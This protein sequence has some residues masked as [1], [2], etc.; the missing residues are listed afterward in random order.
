MSFHC[1]LKNAYLATNYIF[2]VAFYGLSLSLNQIIYFFLFFYLE[3]FK[4][5]AEEL[6]QPALETL[7]T[8]I[9]LWLW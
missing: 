5:N 6:N 9:L 4:S 3:N 7:F 2:S 8:V 1:Q